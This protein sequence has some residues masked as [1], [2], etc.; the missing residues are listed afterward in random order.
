MMPRFAFR[1]MSRIQSGVCP[2]EEDDAPPPVSANGRRCLAPR[3]PF[4]LVTSGAFFCE[5][6]LPAMVELISSADLLR[7][8]MAGGAEGRVCWFLSLTFGGDG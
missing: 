5:S 8:L 3:G 4:P 6:A 7:G 1:K 2:R